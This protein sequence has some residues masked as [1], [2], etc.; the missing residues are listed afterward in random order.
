M[1]KPKNYMGTEIH[2]CSFDKVELQV[3]ARQDHK[4]ESKGTAANYG[5]NKACE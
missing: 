2:L 1:L 5:N 3:S 4:F